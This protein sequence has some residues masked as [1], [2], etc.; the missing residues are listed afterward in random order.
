M[1]T[2]QYVNGYLQSLTGHPFT[3]KNFR[4]WNA[5]REMF[6][7]L[8]KQPYSADGLKATLHEVALLL[9]HTP[10]ICRKSY[11]KP[12]IICWWEDGR[13]NEWIQKQN[14]SLRN[15]DQLLLFWLETQ[16]TQPS[17]I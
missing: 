9:G 16:F 1:I 5:C 13:L 6:C 8:A 11:I 15:K 14:I 3:A 12:E 4:T 7:R 10:A 2:S 17:F